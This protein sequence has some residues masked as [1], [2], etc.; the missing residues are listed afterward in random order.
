MQLEHL[1]SLDWNTLPARLPELSEEDA[2]LLSGFFD[3]LL[4]DVICCQVL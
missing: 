2:Q 3:H 4:S 1:F